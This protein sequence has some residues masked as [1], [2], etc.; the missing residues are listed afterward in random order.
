MGWGF[1][2]WLMVFLSRYSR[3]FS[4]RLFSLIAVADHCQEFFQFV[5][6]QML[7]FDEETDQR[8]DRTTKE[9]AF[10]FLH[11]LAA[12]LVATDKRSEK[13]RLALFLSLF[14]TDKPFLRE[15]LQKCRRG[16]VG[17]LWLGIARQDITHRTT[18]FHLPKVVHDFHFR[19]GQR[20]VLFALFHLANGFFELLNFSFSDGKGS[21]KLLINE[22]FSRRFFIEKQTFNVHY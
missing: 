8:L 1:R 7:F 10:H 6:R 3:F 15:Y 22:N 18:L 17:R 16:G 11:G 4:S 2:G 13:E 14:G 21:T 5:F 19:L 12:V 9:T 20:F